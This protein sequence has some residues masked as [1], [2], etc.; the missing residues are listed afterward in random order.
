MAQTSQQERHNPGSFKQQNKSHKHGKH[1]SKGQLER[2]TKGRVNVKILTKKSKHDIKKTERRNKAKQ[3]RKNKRDEVLTKKRERG[4]QTS[5]PHFVVMV[6]LHPKL[7][8]STC[9]NLLKTCDDTTRV[10]ENEYGMCH[11]SIPRFKQRV[12]VYTP[13]SGRLH[14]LLDAAKVADTLLLLLPPEDEFEDYI[15]EWLTCLFGQGLP[16][17]V[18]AVPGLK[19]LPAKKQ[20]EIKKYLQKRLEKRFPGQKL[21]SLDSSQDA[22]LVLRQITAQKL[23]VIQYRQQRP[24][25]VADSIEFEIDN[26]GTGTLKVSGYLRSQ[27][28]SANSLVHL[29]GWGDFQLSQI[30]ARVD[31]CPLNPRVQKQRKNSESVEMVADDRNEYLLEKADPNKQMSLESEVIPDVMDGEQTWPTEEE[32]AQAEEDAKKKIPKRVPKGTSEY[33]AA[34]IVDSDEEQGTEDSEDDDDDEMVMSNEEYSEEESEE[35]EEEELETVTNADVDE[36]A[37]YDED[38]DMDED[39]RMF[40]KIKAEKQHVMFPDEVDTPKDSNARTRFARYRGLKSFRT[41]AWDPK[42][43]LPADYARIFQFANF[44]QTKKRILRTELDEGALPGWYICIQIVNVPKQFTETHTK[45]RPVVIFGLL[46]H[47]QK[48]SVVNFVLKRCA[49]C[50]KTIESKERLIFQAGFRRFSVCPIFS[51]HTNG[52][53]HKFERFLPHDT[54]VVA[55]VFSP[56]V[57]SPV[58]VLVFRQTPLGEHELVAMGSM[59]NVDPDRVVVKRAVLSGYAFKI[60][61][62]TA[63]VRYMFFNREDISWFKPVE[64]RTKWGRRGHIKEPLG[65]HG[66]MKCVFD[67]QLKSQD[68]ILMNLYKRVYPKWTYNSH[69]SSPPLVHSYTH[70][71]D[72]EE[73]KENAYN[74]F[75]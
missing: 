62:K 39:R 30:D 72:E 47:E 74:L 66:H 15:E 9:L 75:D 59:L 51:Q 69:V 49:N 22:L 63:V 25:L 21:H 34:W 31:P 55:T 5:P 6:S 57:F 36:D 61:K 14:A 1:K 28:L 32:L 45:G 29:P 17:T 4:C 37:M 73:S 16:A 13:E 7:D 42:E 33:Q 54:A 71:S 20:T 65:T 19:T 58:P 64:L 26:A 24:N 27:P 48:M 67:G 23:P 52:N 68:T 18:L 2:D 8:T 53:K 46:P 56:I 35:G 40:N 60:N 11:I 3:M 50:V 12:V 43:N 10:T 41:S 70:S 38:M 44:K